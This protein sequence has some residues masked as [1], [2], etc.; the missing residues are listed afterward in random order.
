MDEKILDD[1]EVEKIFK[2]RTK[3]AYWLNYLYFW[4]TFV[5]LWIML[6]STGMAEEDSSFDLKY[7]FIFTAII[8]SFVLAHLIAKKFSRYEKLDELRIKEG[9]S[10]EEF[11]SKYYGVLEI[12]DK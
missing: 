2:K 9:L 10:Q 5:I 4:L 11:R 3:K 6:S 1:K 8:S 7:G 12:D